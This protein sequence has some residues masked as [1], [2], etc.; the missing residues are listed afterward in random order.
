MTIRLILWLLLATMLLANAAFDFAAAP[1]AYRLAEKATRQA[2]W[3]DSTY[4]PPQHPLRAP[5]RHLDEHFP[6]TATARHVLAAS[7]ALTILPLLIIL[8]FA[9][10]QRRVEDLDVAL[11]ISIGA[12]ALFAKVALWEVAWLLADVHTVF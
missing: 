8:G 6:L 3:P 4:F 1:V 2:K 7:G 12:F 11:A 10:T 9:W 5:L